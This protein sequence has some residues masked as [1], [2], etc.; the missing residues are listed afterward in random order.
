MVKEKEKLSPSEALRRAADRKEYGDI[1]VGDAVVTLGPTQA[2]V[3][4]ANPR[5]EGWEPRNGE[6]KAPTS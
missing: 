6:E 3:A 1:Q 5:G 4:V 2:V